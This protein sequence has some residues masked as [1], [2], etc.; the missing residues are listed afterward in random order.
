MVGFGVGDISNTIE[1]YIL[2]TLLGYLNYDEP[3]QYVPKAA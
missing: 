2:V 1:H 3:P